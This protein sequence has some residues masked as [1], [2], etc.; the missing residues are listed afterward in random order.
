MKKWALVSLNL[1]K[2]AESCD[3]L[4]N[5]GYSAKNLFT[6]GSVAEIKRKRKNTTY[7]T[8]STER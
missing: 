5:R 6:N 1:D 7:R 4:K 8:F 3:R 2:R